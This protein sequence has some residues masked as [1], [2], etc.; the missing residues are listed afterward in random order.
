MLLTLGARPARLWRA[1]PPMAAERYPLNL[2]RFGP[3]EE[4]DDVIQFTHEQGSGLS[5][6]VPPV[7]GAMS[8]S[9]SEGMTTPGPFANAPDVGGALAFSSPDTPGMPGEREDGLGFSA[10]DVGC[11]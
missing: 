7:R 1:V 10:G 2:I 11:F 3:A 5:R 8:P 6:F 4:R 9:S